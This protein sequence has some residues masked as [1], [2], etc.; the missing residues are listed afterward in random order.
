[1]KSDAA[2]SLLEALKERLSSIFFFNMV[3]SFVYIKW[4]F[5]YFTIFDS[6]LNYKP[7]EYISLAKTYLYS[8]G[9]IN[10]IIYFAFVITLSFPIIN[11]L[12]ANFKY[13]INKMVDWVE[14]KIID[15]NTPASGKEFA[16]VKLELKDLK[17]RYTT[18]FSEEN[19]NLE[20]L[21]ILEEDSE[22]KRLETE[23]FVIIKDKIETENNQLKNELI[24]VKFENTNLQNSL[25]IPESFLER[26]IIL[27]GVEQLDE[28]NTI[29]DLDV[30]NYF[31]EKY[32]N[33]IYG[34]EPFDSV[35]TMSFTPFHIQLGNESIM[36]THVSLKND[37]LLIFSSDGLKKFWIEFNIIPDFKNI[38]K[39]KF[40]FLSDSK[41]AMDLC[42][43][44]S[45]A[46]VSNRIY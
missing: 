36:I 19:R 2:E 42:S 9:T 25:F 38:Y 24:K 37:K 3:I 35:T 46:F 45:H 10:E 16:D 4:Q 23:Q 11:G 27:F 5:V 44:F 12:Y 8:N 18:L 26:K 30:Y 41:I 17:T 32:S 34:F 20:R 6:Y 43:K 31:V 28:I 7:G 13:L 15:K 33:N 1:M 21:K 14:I 29:K 40:S 22:K 39:I